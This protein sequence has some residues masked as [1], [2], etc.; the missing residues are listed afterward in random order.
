[1]AGSGQGRY[2]D[3]LRAR[4]LRLLLGA[5]VVDAVGGWAYNVVVIVYLYDRTGSPGLIAVFTAC[6]WMPRLLLSTYAGVLADR[7]ERTRLMVLSALTCFGLGLAMSAAVA[8][9]VPVVVLLAVHA[10]LAGANTFYR[11]AAQ[12]VVPDAVPEK[13]LAAA[14]ALFGV[15]ENLV[16]VVGPALG[17]LLL[18][19]GAPV[20]GVL[21]NAVT[22][23]LAA[24]LV[25]RLG[26]RSTGSAEPDDGGL[27]QQVGT[28]LAA[29]R[30]EPVALVLVLYCALDSAVY[31]ALT[32]LYVPMS[33][34]FGTGSD[35]YSYLVA[36]MALG[37][38][39]AGGLVNRLGGSRHLSLVI[40][41]GM[42]LLALPLA[43]STL[44][45]SALPGALLQV[46]AG[47]GMVVVD[48]LAVTALQRDLPRGVLSRVF[49]VL[50]TL[51]LAGVL[52]A[53]LAA[54]VLLATTSL[55]T[56]LLVLGLGF[57]AASVAGMGPLLAADR[58]SADAL[59][60]LRPRIAML[61]VLDLFAVAPRTTLEQLARALEQVELPDG[62]VVVR[63]GEPADALYVVVSG[64]VEVLAR[65]ERE[66]EQL[67]RTLG[68]RSCFG[69]IGLLRGGVRTAT[70]RTTEPTVL[71]R[72]SGPDFLAAV[73]QGQASA[74]IV[75]L[76]GS[77]LA[78]TH[79]ALAA[80]PFAP[81][82]G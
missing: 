77:R 75:R 79:P 1:V 71:W 26:L 74:S 72:L 37:G 21:L 51:V 27:R 4:D 10:L 45:S 78:R 67:V 62:A 13:D 50:E 43:L 7:Y 44:V 2:R 42:C 35:G 3:A 46:V 6:G 40:V 32:V 49:G 19:T 70:V 39:L 30:G 41:G 17:G 36:S 61:E 8:V 23:L 28:G 60:A 64:E 68:A 38:V 34:S 73:E 15:L 31:G 9:D 56:T 55:T 82:V 48:V 80:E 33:Q 58:R 47:V 81:P 25:Q 20:A 63:E 12:A 54:S 29:L 22:F 18:L 66:Q 52:L 5:F 65:G 11:P 59:A 14:N 16:V 69:E 24:L 76:V 57:T 53:S